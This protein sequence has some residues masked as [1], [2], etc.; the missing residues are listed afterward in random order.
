M[1]KLISAILLLIAA[2]L[3]ASCGGDSGSEKSEPATTTPPVVIDPV[4]PP[5]D[6]TDPTPDTPAEETPSPEPTQP[7]T[8]F[9]PNILI[10]TATGAYLSDG[11][12][13]KPLVTG[14]VTYTGQR[15]LIVGSELIEYD[16]TG[17][18]TTRFTFDS[19][20]VQALDNGS[21]YHCLET[22]PDTALSLGA[23]AKW[24]SEFF[25]D[26][27]SLD[28]WFMNQMRCTDLVT[29]NGIVWNID[30]NGSHQIVDGVASGVEHIHEPD[31]YI[32]SLDI[33]NQRIEF[34]DQVPQDY[35]F[36]YIL[37]AEQWQFF[38]G[39]FYSENGYTWSEAAGLSEAVN[40]LD[41]WNAAPFPVSLPMAQYPRLIAAG[42]HDGLLYWIES[43]TGWL[44]SFDPAGD[45]IEQVYRL[46][47]GDGMTSTGESKDLRPVMV[48]P[49][50]YYFDGG[51]IQLDMET[52]FSSL[53]YAGGADV[54]KW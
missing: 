6:E 13:T 34:N 39:L 28:F 46:Y 48:W 24:Y 9:S 38:D 50:L 53:F 29:A 47:E 44:M 32:H 52:G 35:A 8:A 25:K 33:V 36:N 42:V 30:E 43:N 31:F 54:Y 1:K 14:V 49:Y 37:K 10:I 41:G 27:V 45:S 21:V 2:F 7:E 15:L 16:A 51:W 18:G 23:Q 20:P 3:L 4:S 26:G 19:A 17:D 40:A 22:D 5:A 12:T 11:E